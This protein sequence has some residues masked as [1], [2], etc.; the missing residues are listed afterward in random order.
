MSI[1]G[2]RLAGAQFANVC[3][4]RHVS[5]QVSVDGPYSVDQGHVGPS[6]YKATRVCPYGMR[7]HEERRST[8]LA[9]H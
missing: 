6:R 2:S 5:P 4:N 3:I 8:K 9:K 1:G 7:T